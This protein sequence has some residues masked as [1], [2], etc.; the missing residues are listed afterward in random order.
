MLRR[1]RRL[2]LGSC[3]RCGRRAACSGEGWGG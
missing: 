3:R 2:L 1:M